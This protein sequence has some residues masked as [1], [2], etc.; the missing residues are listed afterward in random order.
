MKSL[1]NKTVLEKR[2]LSA[3]EELARKDFDNEDI[4]KLTKVFDILDKVG[5]RVNNNEKSLIS[6]YGG[7][8]TQ[9]GVSF[10][11]KEKEQEFIK[12]RQSFLNKTFKIKEI[13]IKSEKYPL[14]LIRFLYGLVKFI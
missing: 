2:F 6:D 7:I 12:E 9:N 8:A 14:I 10:P 11:D 4:S 13:E 3:L 5:E 1:P